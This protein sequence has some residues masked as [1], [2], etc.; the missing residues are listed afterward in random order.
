MTRTTPK[1]ADDACP[2]CGTLLNAATAGPMNPDAVP[3]P[4]DWTICIKCAGVL[5]FTDDLRVRE[6]T[7][8]ELAEAQADPN[9]IS[10]II[11]VAEMNKR[12]THNA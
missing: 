10:G 11:V 4:G 2:F 7:D 6:L 8:A 3:D 1:P 9:I 12:N 5:T